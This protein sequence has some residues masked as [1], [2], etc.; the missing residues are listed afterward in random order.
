MRVLLFAALLVTP[1]AAQTADPVEA[2]TTQLRLTD[3]QADLVAEVFSLEDPGSA[4]TLA[5]E[6]LPVLDATQRA[7]LFERPEQVDRP[8]RAAR[9]NRGARGQRGP[10]GGE[11]DPAR[12]AIA[13]AA[14]DAALGLTPSR[15]ADLDATLEGLDRRERMD[16]FRNGTLPTSIEQLLTSD[17]IDV[18]R[19]QAAIQMHVRRAMRA[20]RRG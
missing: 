19:A 4:W 15:S 20:N 7:A 11:P 13:K 9:G 5:A 10:R 12:T 17:Q 2:L 6:L 16:A 8:E 3:D 14:R 18:Y 1:L